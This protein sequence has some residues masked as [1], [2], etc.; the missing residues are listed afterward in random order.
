MLI[1]TRTLLLPSASWSYNKTMPSLN[2]CPN[3]FDKHLHIFKS[4]GSTPHWP[5]YLAISLWVKYCIKKQL[6]SHF[7]KQ[8]LQKIH[9]NFGISITYNELRHPM[10]PN[11]HVIIYFLLNQK[12]LSLLEPFLPIWIIYQLS[13]KWHLCSIRKIASWNLWRHFPMVHSRSIEAC[14]VHFF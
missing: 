14:I 9:C 2:V 4:I 10:V 7:S 3:L 13:P 1:W 6:I 11:S 5:F 12:L 8:I